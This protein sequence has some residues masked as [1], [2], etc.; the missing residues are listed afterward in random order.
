MARFISTQTI[1][2]ELPLK[3]DYLPEIGA[4]VRAS[5][6]EGAVVAGGFFLAATVARQ[7]I[8]VGVASTLGTG[9]NSVQARHSLGRESIS[10]LLPE[11]VGDIG[12]RIV[13]IDSEGTRTIITSP[14]VETEPDP[15]DFTKVVLR[16]DDWALINLN[17]LAYPQLATA[18]SEWVQSLPSRVHLALAGGPLVGAVDLDVLVKT[19]RRANLLTLNKQQADA[20]GSRIGRGPISDILRR[21]LQPEAHLVLRDGSHGAAIQENTSQI[22]IGIPA[23]QGEIVDTTGVGDAHTGVLIAALMQGM[24]LEEAAVRAN[25]AATIVLRRRGYY[26]VPTAAQIDE[27]LSAH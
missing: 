7:G 26:K 11:T 22:P 6:L 10:V 1:T 9:P 27:F 14:G 12:L 5:V 21:Y 16:P 17:D 3:V 18:L 23:F 4:E 13:A 20:I 8:A 24:S 19:M 2:L 25:A 15:Q